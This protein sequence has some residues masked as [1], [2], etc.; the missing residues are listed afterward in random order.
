MMYPLVIELAADGIPV[1]VTCRVLGF[2]SRR[3]T[4]GGPPRSLSGTGTTHT[5]MTTWW[6]DSSP[7]PAKTGSGSAISLSTQPVK[8]SSTL[9][10]IKDVW[11][12]RIVGYSI[13]V[14][15]PEAT[16]PLLHMK[17]STRPLK[18]PDH[19]LHPTRQPNSGQHRKE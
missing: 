11:S 4:N 15:E 8:A 7:P 10:A 16:S 6:T 19:P 3:S 2:S 17:S 18:R 5:C 13:D 9:C 1:T 12:N 14:N